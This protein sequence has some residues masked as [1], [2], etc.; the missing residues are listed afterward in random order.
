VDLSREEISASLILASKLVLGEL[1]AILE[2]CPGAVLI[3]GSVPSLLIPQDVEPHEG[4]VDIDVVLDLD[5]PG[6]DADLTLHE[7]LERALFIQDPKRPYRYLRM[8]DIHGK[9][10]QILIE[11]LAGGNPPPNGL[12]RIQTEDIFVTIIEGVEVALELSKEVPLPGQSERRVMVASLPAFIAMKAKAL[13]RREERLKTKDAY[14]IVYCLRN[15]PGGLDA[16][17]HTFRAASQNK[18]VK[19]AIELLRAQFQTV[20]A[21]GPIAYAQLAEDDETALLMQRE[22]YERVT[23]LLARLDIPSED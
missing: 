22:A 15:Y 7:M 11:F 6:I 20:E 23:D 17:V 3:G 8:V 13:S 1:A 12:R 21:L 14:D 19:T 18:I 9:Q 10:F 2:N 5:Q 16:V 4:T